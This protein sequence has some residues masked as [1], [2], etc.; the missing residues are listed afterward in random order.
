MKHHTTQVQTGTEA[1]IAQHFCWENMRKTAQQACGTCDQ[2]QHA[3]QQMMKC[4][5]L[6]AKQ[7][8][9]KP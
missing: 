4:G 8:E 1:T 9:V 7:A 6:P 3:K 2:C 5:E